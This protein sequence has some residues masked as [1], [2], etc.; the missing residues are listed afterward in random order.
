MC[1][2]VRRDGFTFLVKVMHQDQLGLWAEKYKLKMGCWRN[3]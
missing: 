2:K 3:F 1:L